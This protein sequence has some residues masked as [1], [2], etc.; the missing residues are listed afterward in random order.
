MSADRHLVAFLVSNP[1]EKPGRISLRVISPQDPPGTVP[2]EAGNWA[3]VP[4]GVARSEVAIQPDGHILFDVAHRFDPPETDRVVVGVAEAGSTPKVDET[5]PQDKFLTTD[6]AVWPELKNYKLPPAL[7]KLAGR[8][9]S[10]RGR[11]AG[12]TTHPVK[13][14]LVERDL[15]EVVQGQAGSPDTSVVCAGGELLETVA[16]APDGHT[17]AV[18]AGA[19]TELL[20]LDGEHTPATLLRGRLLAWRP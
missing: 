9:L 8:V 11:V 3:W 13:T 6:H 2:L 5:D 15:H 18:V 17:V 16:F 1:P 12:G 7:P 19:N 14:F 4:D 20:D 10:T